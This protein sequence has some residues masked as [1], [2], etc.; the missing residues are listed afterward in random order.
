M[1]IACN[2][3]R[4]ALGDRLTPFLSQSVCLTKSV[5]SFL[6]RG[7]SRIFGKPSSGPT[8]L[9]ETSLIRARRLN[10]FM[11]KECSSQF[12]FIALCLSILLGIAGQLLLKWSAVHVIGAPMNGLSL[13]Q[14]GTAL[15]IYSL[16][17]V[18]WVL[19]LQHLRLSVA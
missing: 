8:T 1:L 4:V 3:N 15:L 2:F 14:L 18:N 7:D 12:A 10:K 17:V 11:R 6:P 9:A 13:L 16:G 5:V 19:A